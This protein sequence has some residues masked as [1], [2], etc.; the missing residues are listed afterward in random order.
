M[1]H[2]DLISYYL[3]LCHLKF[4]CHPTQKYTINGY[5]QISI[6]PLIIIINLIQLYCKE[7]NKLQ[8]KIM[9]YLCRVTGIW[10]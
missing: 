4:V 6:D 9:I 10:D 7:Y 5:T 1:G 8:G 2:N 3:K